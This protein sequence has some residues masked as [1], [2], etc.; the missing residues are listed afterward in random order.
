MDPIHIFSDVICP[1]CFVGKARLDRALAELG[2]TGQVELVWHPFELDPGTPPEGKDRAKYLSRY[3]GPEQ[4]KQMD[5]R[6][7][8]LAADAGIQGFDVAKASRIP[9]TFQAHRLMAWAGRR[10]KAHDLA[11]ALF[12]AN[13]MAGEDVSK[14][15]VL[16]KAAESV[17]LD[18]AE[19]ATWLKGDELTDELRAEEDQA[20]RLGIQGVPFYVINGQGLSGA[21]PLQVFLAALN[22]AAAEGP[23]KP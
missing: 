13:F 23:A 4:L 19:A 21:Q 12:R 15:E 3:G 18:G 17:G 11:E 5:A 14:L 8:G 20:R 6:L 2:L 10:G 16:V 7:N 22:A 9:N 1:W